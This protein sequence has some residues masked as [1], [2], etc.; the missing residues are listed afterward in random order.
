MDIVLG[1]DDSIVIVTE[2]INP[3]YVR[4]ANREFI[5]K[6]NHAMRVSFA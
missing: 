4:R 3:V 5:S 2:S 1:N 6:R